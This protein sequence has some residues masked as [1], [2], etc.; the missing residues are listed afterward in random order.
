MEIKIVEQKDWEM[1]KN[2]VPGDLLRKKAVVFAATK[3]GKA[4]G[5]LVMEKGDKDY[6]VSVLWVHPDRRRNHIASALLDKAVEYAKNTDAEE[7]SASYDAQREDSYILDYMF[8]RKRFQVEVEKVPRYR[9]T[10][11]L[12]K[13][14]SLFM[15]MKK[16]TKKNPNIVPFGKLTAYQLNEMQENFMKNGIHMVSRINLS[17][18]DG[19]RSLVLLSDNAVKGLLLLK[20]K[21]IPTEFEMVLFFVLPSQA[22][23]AVSLLLQASDV[24][25]DEPDMVQGVE[26]VCVNTKSY[27]LAQKIL[28]VA[29]HDTVSLC[30]AALELD[31]CRI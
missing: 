2:L 17:E 25:F 23:A 19:K 26:F 8:V 4:E 15:E 7:I 24:L 6:S 12:L 20:R 21:E 29:K 27:L 18:I 9:I 11:E 13:Q 28:G 31:R 1:V 30:H 5:I 3:R 10:A 22:A 16:K 14:S